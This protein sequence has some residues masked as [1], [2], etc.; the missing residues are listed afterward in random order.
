M[1]IV[2]IS[3]KFKNNVILDKINYTTSYGKCIGLIGSNGTG[4]STLLDI[5]AGIQK[6]DSGKI[7]FENNDLIGY[8]PQ[9]NPLFEELSVK[10]NLE[11]WKKFNK[12]NIDKDYIENLYE[13]FKI[14][15]MLKKKVSILSG[16]MKKRVSIVIALLK[17]PNILI[18]DEPS[19]ALDLVFKQELKNTIKYFKS[20]GGIVIL[21]THDESE[22][23]ICDEIIAIKNKKIEI[24][25]KNMNIKDI[26]ENYIKVQ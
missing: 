15:D 3:K 21:V 2:N 13:I 1:K 17:K 20:T 4:K 18:L 5:I 24:V 25:D 22:L 9:D 19:N 14:K 7:E 16:G 26:I 6:A 12:K 10:D 11:L 8:V 23:N